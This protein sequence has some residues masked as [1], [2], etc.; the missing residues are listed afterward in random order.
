MLNNPS[1]KT[2]LLKELL[3]LKRRKF[4]D[5]YLQNIIVKEKQLK[6]FRERLKAQQKYKKGLTTWN[7]TSFLYNNMLIRKVEVL[8]ILSSISEV[9]RIPDP[10]YIYL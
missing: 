7:E 4:H 6:G 8:L 2:Y 5:N 3:R 1:T 10:F 9:S